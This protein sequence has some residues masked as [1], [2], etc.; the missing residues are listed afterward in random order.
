MCMLRRVHGRSL[1]TMGIGLVYLQFTLVVT[2]NNIGPCKS[3]RAL[4]FHKVLVTYH[5]FL[6]RCTCY[7]RPAIAYHDRRSSVHGFINPTA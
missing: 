5:A 2:N 1:F 3:T 4:A 6:Y 7:A